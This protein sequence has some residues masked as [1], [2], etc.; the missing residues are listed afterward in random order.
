M[1][2]V[3]IERRSSLYIICTEGR[4]RGG[5]GF[6]IQ[7]FSVEG[8][9]CRLLLTDRTHC[10]MMTGEVTRERRGEEWPVAP[11]WWRHQGTTGREDKI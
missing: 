4:R 3:I 2:T 7:E 10:S 6:D 5:G 11:G 8:G 1:L 9:S